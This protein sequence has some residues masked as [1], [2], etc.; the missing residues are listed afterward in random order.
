MRTTKNSTLVKIHMAQVK[1]GM[2]IHK[3]GGRWRDHPFWR[4][5]F[6]VEDV[7]TLQTLQA[8][9][10]KDVWIDTS[11]GAD[12]RRVTSNVLLEQATGPAVESEPAFE[13]SEFGEEIARA[14]GIRDRAKAVAI[15]LLQDVRMGNTLSLDDA[16]DIVNELDDAI[17]RQPAAMLSVLRLKNKDDYTYLHSVAVAALMI[18]LGRQLN[19]E[20]DVLK[21]LGMAGLLHDIGKVGVS[22]TI[23]N[24]PGPL[25]AKEMSMVRMHPQIGWDTLQNQ[26]GISPVALDVCLHH[27]EKI[28]GSGYPEQLAGAKIS[29]QARMGAICDIYDAVTSDRPYKNGWEPAEA[30][31][32]MAKWQ[33]GHFDREIFHAFVKLIGIYPTGTLLRLASHRLAVVLC[34]GRNSALK[35]IVRVFRALPS[36]EAIDP[37]LIDLDDH[38]DAIVGIEHPSD[39]DIDVLEV[40]SA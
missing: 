16:K 5:S 37:C 35:P 22:D 14:K 32:Q 13:R 9:G 11:K 38:E 3:I 8:L 33:N 19:A 24:K 23:L 1:R 30:I 21:D 10:D 2:F 25:D 26:A 17:S 27:H 12:I 39:W 6:L 31:R 4:R 29:F 18:A 15:V 20:D 7:K 34:Q 28:D 36:N 40:L